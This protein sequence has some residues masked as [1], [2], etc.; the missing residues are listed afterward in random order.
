MFLGDFAVRIDSTDPP[1][2]PLLWGEL[3]LELRN[4]AS[5]SF[6]LAREWDSLKC[7]RVDCAPRFL[8]QG[9][10]AQTLE[11]ERRE[12]IFRFGLL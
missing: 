9:V 1:R 10:R 6:H 3:V 8:I 12:Q 2:L 11:M 4:S 5:D 7:D